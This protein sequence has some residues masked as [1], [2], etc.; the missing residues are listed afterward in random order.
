MNGQ[1]INLKEKKLIELLEDPT[2]KQFLEEILKNKSIKFIELYTKLKIPETTARHHLKQLEESEI[3]EKFKE[4]GTRSLKIKINPIYLTLV[5]RKFN[6][7]KELC[8]YGM[9]GIDNEGK[10]F[11]DVY[12]RF[13]NQNITFKKFYFGMT[14]GTNEKETKESKEWMKLVKEYEIEFI[15]THLNNFEIIIK[16]LENKL[17]EIIED[18]NP[19]IN[20]TRGTKIHSIVLSKL[21]QKYTLDCYYLPEGE[22]NIILLP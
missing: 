5:R 16:D 11:L 3:I 1:E 21:G 20:I 10:G 19:I 6:I 18:Y 15:T 12:K 8:Y 22:N 14:E 4:K 2:R 7:K 13:K 17:I 9:V